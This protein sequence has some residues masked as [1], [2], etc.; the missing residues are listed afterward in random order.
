MFLIIQFVSDASPIQKYQI[1]YF[2][3]MYDLCGLLKV[4]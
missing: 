1:A 3:V 4:L 2:L